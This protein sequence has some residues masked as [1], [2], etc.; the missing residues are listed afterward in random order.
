ME[1]NRKSKEES[2]T[3]SGRKYITDATK[4]ALHPIRAQILKILK[5]APKTAVELGEIIGESHFNLY[6]HLTTL[7]EIGLVRS[8]PV[9][10]KTKRYELTIPRKPEAAVLIFTEDDIDSHPKEFTALVAAAEMLEK[11]KIPH[12]EKIVRAEISFYYSWEKD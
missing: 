6:Y 1:K 3:V 10:K 2:K 5:D 9:D 11:S 8:T 7:E 4:A 12:C